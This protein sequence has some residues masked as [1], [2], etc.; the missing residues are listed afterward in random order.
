MRHIYGL[1]VLLSLLIPV[2][3]FV[4]SCVR[5]AARDVDHTTPHHATPA[6]EIIRSTL[7]FSSHHLAGEVGRAAF[8]TVIWPDQIR[9]SQ[10]Q[11]RRQQAATQD[12]AVSRGPHAKVGATVIARERLQRSAR[13]GSA[14]TR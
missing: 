3:R 2:F 12:V 6:G 10:R 4:A 8:R 7:G 1:N 5:V 14:A 13:A 9:P 11:W